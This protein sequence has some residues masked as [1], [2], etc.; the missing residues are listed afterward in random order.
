[1][2]RNVISEVL[3]EEENKE[4]EEE[5]EEMKNENFAIE[6]LPEPNKRKRTI[7]QVNNNQEENSF[8]D[9]HQVIITITSLL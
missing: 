1:M 9:D 6:Y 8:D 5:E 3:V 2:Y 7:N 4:E